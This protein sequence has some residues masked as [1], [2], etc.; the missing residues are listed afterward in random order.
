M[1]V[2]PFRVNQKVRHVRLGIV[3]IVSIDDYGVRIRV[4][5]GTVLVTKK[6]AMAIL[7]PIDSPAGVTGK[8]LILI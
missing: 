7:K 3:E 6:S 8:Q 5:G 2:F 4:S 1:E